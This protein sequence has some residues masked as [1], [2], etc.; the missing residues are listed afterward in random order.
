LYSLWYGTQK[1]AYTLEARNANLVQAL[2]VSGCVRVGVGDAVWVKHFANEE[3]K[4]CKRFRC[5][6]GEVVEVG[7]PK[8]QV[9]VHIKL[10]RWETVSVP[11]WCVVHA[12]A[13]APP[14]QG[15]EKGACI[16]GCGVRVYWPGEDNVFAGEV[17]AW[18]PKS[19]RHTI[20]YED[21]DVQE[22]LLGGDE[23]P[24]WVYS[25]L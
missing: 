23:A 18:D 10:T 22:E 15:S 14:M 2:E 21:G 25:H 7:L 17:T 9:V 4:R 5:V 19:G 13:I 12:G 11:W 8:G 24:Y 3:D 16:V 6:W 20:H 1:N